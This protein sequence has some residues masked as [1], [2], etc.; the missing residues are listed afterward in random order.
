MNN[1]SEMKPYHILLIFICAICLFS[2]CENNRVFESYGSISGNGWHKDSVLNYNFNIKDSALN[3]NLYF[4]LRNTVDYPYSNIWL[5]VSIDPQH[6]NAITDTVEFILAG[7]GGR[8]FGRGH[9][10]YRD[11]KL[12]YQN[13]VFFPDTGIYRF[14]VQQGMRD[15]V[16]E[17][18]NDFGIRV[19][20]VK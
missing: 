11:N 9:G 15:N 6:G 14:N 4:N 18:I 12:I 16:L 19:E 7:P 1:L 17:G 13:N 10:K 5:F 8:W 20:K 3:Y 2:A